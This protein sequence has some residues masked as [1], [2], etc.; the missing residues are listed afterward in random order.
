MRKVQKSGRVRS[1]FG[2]ATGMSVGNR[3]NAL[4]PHGG[5]AANPL[6]NIYSQ[7]DVRPRKGTAIPSILSIKNLSSE[8]IFYGRKQY[9]ENY[10]QKG[11]GP[12]DFCLD[13]EWGETA[14]EY[15]QK[16]SLHGLKYVGD[17]EL[18]LCERFLWLVTFVIGILAAAYYITI[19]YNRWKENPMI[20][21]LSPRATLL[22]TIP[23]P[24][25]TVCNMNGAKKSVA[26]DIDQNQSNDSDSLF[27]KHMLRKL[28]RDN[29]L[30]SGS[31][32]NASWSKMQNF[33][34][35]V[36]QPC[37][38]MLVACLWRSEEMPCHAMFNPEITDEGMCC[39]FNKVKRNFIYRNPRQLHG[40]NYTFPYP[41]IDWTPESG[42]PP[43]APAN[44]NPWRVFG[45]GK[46]LGLTIVLDA[47]L[48]DYYCSSTAS[49]GFKVLLH[50]PVETPRVSE[51]AYFITP[52]DEA[53]V[54]ITPKIST[55][56][57]DLVNIPESKRRCVFTS[58]RNLRFYRTYTQRNCELECQS[59]FTLQECKCVPFYLPKDS[60]TRI[61]GTADDECVE[62][63][64]G[65]GYSM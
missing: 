61:C 15:C 52:G 20:I 22:E 35:K 57:P 49:V 54:E 34:V 16:T 10:P 64:K 2:S 31:K 45:P 41:S 28:C 6:R 12:I 32:V 58:E 44:A 29:E 26:E 51:F 62:N 47:E 30:M 4:Q 25:V 60:S 42:Y 21:S 33:M 13:L 65:S 3:L 14:K 48:F 9:P 55:T 17:T 8:K 36:S 7:Y 19:L 53:R 18:S 24:A 59:N 43:D 50:S 56:T 39:S 40:L 5:L 1:V 37:H 38:T 46:G 23:F 27:E 63:V 11:G